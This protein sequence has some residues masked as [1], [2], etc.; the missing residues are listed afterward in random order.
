MVYYHCQDPRDI[1]LK[2]EAAVA[3][4]YSAGILNAQGIFFFVSV[5]SLGGDKTL[6]ISDN[7]AC[8]FPIKMCLFIRSGLVQ[9]GLS[10]QGRDEE[11]ERERERERENYQTF[12]TI[13][14]K[15]LAS[16]AVAY[17]PGSCQTF[18]MTMAGFFWM[19]RMRTGSAPSKRTTLL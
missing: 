18:D 6:N 8:L 3:C 19:S 17:P 13:P 9:S 5:V 16:V 12:R 15:I 1:P 10:H 14:A 2:H 7:Y 4:E 11:T